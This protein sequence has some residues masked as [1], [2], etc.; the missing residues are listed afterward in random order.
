MRRWRRRLGLAA[1]M[2]VAVPVVAVVVATLAWRTVEPPLTMLQAIRLVEGRGFDRRVVPLDALG[3]HLPRL[4]IASEDN[5]FCRHR[6]VDWVAVDAEWRR[7]RDGKTPR[8]A[9][10]L[11]MQLTRN[12]YLWPDRGHVRKVLELG[13]TPVVDALLPKRRIVEIYLNQVELAPG[14]Y[15]A[16]AGARHHFGKPAAGLSQGEAARLVALLPGP[17]VRR[18]GDAVVRRHA[19]RIRRRVDQLG[20]LLDCLD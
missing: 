16:E 5:R 1:A 12:L 6:G 3:P 7:W 13:L 18:P 17:L 8:G 9:S 10:T 2:A 19:E 20:P 4:L 14:V 11:T 15:G